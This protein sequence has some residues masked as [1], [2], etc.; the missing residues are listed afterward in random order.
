MR[1]EPKKSTPRAPI[2]N[3]VM[4]TGEGVLSSNAMT[5]QRFSKGKSV[6]NLGIRSALCVPI[7]A[8]AHGHQR[9]RRN[10]RRDLRRQLG[11]EL[12]LFARPTSPARRDRFAGG[13][14]D[15]KRQALPG[16][17]A[18]RTHGRH[19][20]NHR[21]PLTLDQEHPASTS[22]RRG[23]RRDGAE[24]QQLPQTKKAGASSIAISRRSTT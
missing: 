15:P 13:H 20:R 3:H 2:I 14:G 24:G 5:D 18:G 10:P 21:R 23:C 17:F 1:P 8:R 9:R 19:R 6:H 22:R 11:Q 12:H 16:G 4:T 7:K